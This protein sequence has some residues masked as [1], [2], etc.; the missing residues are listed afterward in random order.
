M[1]SQYY[2]TLRSALGVCTGCSPRG[3]AVVSTGELVS[4]TDDVAS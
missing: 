2:I 3:S 1:T 4:T